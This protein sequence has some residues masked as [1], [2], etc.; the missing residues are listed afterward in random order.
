MARADGWHSFERDGLWYEGTD[1]DE[2]VWPDY[3]WEEK[4]PKRVLRPLPPRISARIPAETTD[5]I[6]D[7]LHKDRPSLL[8]CARVSRQWYSRSQYHLYTIF[9]MGRVTFYELAAI[10]KTIPPAKSPLRAV[11]TLTIVESSGRTFL[12]AVPVSLGPHM[13]HI[14]NLHLLGDETPVK[15]QDKPS[16]I[17]L[18]L[19]APFL[20]LFPLLASNVTHFN[21]D[22]WTLSSFADLQRLLLSLPRLQE[23]ILSKLST[24]GSSRAIVKPPGAS[25][26]KLQLLQRLVMK[27]LARNVLDVFASWLISVL[28]PLVLRHVEYTVVDPNA[29]PSDAMKRLLAGF[30][31][32]IDQLHIALHD[33]SE[34]PNMDGCLHLRWLQLHQHIYLDS[35][36][37]KF[38]DHL[39]HVLRDIP[40][41][42][43]RSLSIIFYVASSERSRNPIDTLVRYA[44]KLDELDNALQ[45]HDNEHPAGHPKP[46]KLTSYPVFKSLEVVD[47]ILGDV[48]VSDTDHI[49]PAYRAL[50][51]LKSVFSRWCGGI[52]RAGCREGDGSEDWRSI[53]CPEDDVRSDERAHP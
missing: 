4:L 28:P 33:D 5:L 30:G 16:A 40:S 36:A 7:F 10:V 9:T 45:Q 25:P 13:C 44:A 51:Q 17:R 42:R 50:T 11:R 46:F 52:V 27:R 23:L 21:L 34:P 14:A 24:R 19:D 22:T 12:R 20:I 3:P 38:R 49:A 2:D 48:T 26:Q 39:A 31:N 15:P 35:D 47:V 1:L 53:E 8:A 18:H 29:W 6:I 43:M 41:R 32:S 37:T